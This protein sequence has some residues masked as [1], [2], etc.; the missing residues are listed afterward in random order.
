MNILVVNDDGIDSR[1]IHELAGALS[2]KAGAKVYVC[3]PDGQRSAK[4]HMLNIEK[5]ITVEERDFTGAEMAWATSG[6]PADCVKIGFML[7][8]KMN[9]KIDMVFAGI[10]HGSNIGTDTIYSGTV[11]AA[12]EGTVCG[13]PSVAVSVQSHHATHFEYAC[14][15]AVETAA[16]AFGRM[17]SKTV[18]NINVPDLPS[19]QVK[20]VMYTCLG[21]KLYDNDLIEIRM[22]DGSIAYRYGGEPIKQENLPLTVDVMAEQ[23]GYA[24]IT[25]LHTDMTYSK[26]L[27][28]LNKWKIGR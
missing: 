15:L 12:L 26:V 24:S 10:N 9:I 28:D 16:K 6:S 5:P 1:G 21:E 20:G 13:V 18:L 11:A 23:E 22:E 4:S 17:D 2:G 27:R 25:P 7:L 8:E 3:A 19:D 14:R